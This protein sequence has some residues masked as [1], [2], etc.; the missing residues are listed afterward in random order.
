[1]ISLRPLAA[2]AM[3]LAATAILAL[4]ACHKNADKSAPADKTADNAAPADKAAPADNA[5]PADKPAA[6][7]GIGVTIHATLT[8]SG[9]VN[10]TATFTQHTNDVSDCA[11]WAAKRD[12]FTMPRDDGAKMANGQTVF[13]DDNPGHY[14]GPGM[15][16]AADLD[17]NAATLSINGS[18]EPFQ[19]GKDSTRTLT[20][21]AD[22]SGT[23][24]FANWIDP[25]SSK[26]SGTLTWTCSK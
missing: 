3:P 10:G 4:P 9:K 8:I 19:P 5:A 2:I 14:H 1:M 20:V 21:N 26:E 13:L 7:G 25:G 23:Y 24:A 6:T 16:A 22:G 18:D 12:D 11:A 17:Q 15:Y